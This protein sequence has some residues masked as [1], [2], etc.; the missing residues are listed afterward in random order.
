[1]TKRRNVLSVFYH[2][3]IVNAIMTLIVIIRNRHVFWNVPLSTV[4]GHMG[5]GVVINERCK[6]GEGCCVAQN[7]TIGSREV[8]GPV[9]TIEDHVILLANCAVFGDVTIGHHSVV[10]AGSVVFDSCPPYS[11]VAGGDCIAVIKKTIND[12]DYRRYE[13]VF[14][15]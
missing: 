8:D 4:F 14:I 2:N 5:V 9:P 15:P 10:A 3:V 12:E 6:I 13:R 1:M 11:F 7:V